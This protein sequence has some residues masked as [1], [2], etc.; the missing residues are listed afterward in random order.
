MPVDSGRLF[1]QLFATNDNEAHFF[2]EVANAI[3]GLGHSPHLTYLSPAEGERVGASGEFGRGCFVSLD[4]RPDL[5]VIGKG[6]EDSSETRCVFESLLGLPVL[7]VA[8]CSHR[9]VS[10]LT[11]IGIRGVCVSDYV[12][13]MPTPA[14]QDTLETGPE[15]NG[16]VE[17]DE[18]AGRRTLVHATGDSCEK[19]WASAMQ[20]AD[21]QVERT[22]V[23]AAL[24][25]VLA[26]SVSRD[27]AP[28][29]LVNAELEK[30]FA[31]AVGGGDYGGP[32]ETIVEE[33]ARANETLQRI[34]SSRSW[35]IA[36]WLQ[37]VPGGA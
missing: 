30:A 33:L 36:C 27:W 32:R 4:P 35:K 7:G 3:Q 22:A 21:L 5:V 2:T 6:L 19:A 37:R 25:E 12:V 17:L 29:E 28:W 20:A 15:L 11:R 9:R 14:F 24:A 26:S 10:L 34:Y 23:E 1:V 13:A 31:A 16:V 8:N 18:G